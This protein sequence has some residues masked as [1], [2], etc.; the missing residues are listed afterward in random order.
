MS[1][2]HR[3][4]IVDDHRMLGELLTE[5]LSAEPDLRVAGYAPSADADIEGLLGRT[6]PDV[7]TVEIADSGDGADLVERIAAVSPRPRIVVLTASTDLAR[8][9][10]AAR[11]GA[12]AWLSKSAGSAE[13]AATVRAVCAGHTVYPSAQLGAVLRALA[14]GGADT[15][16]EPL[17]DL[18]R[19]ERRVLQG[20]VDGVR[21][22]DLAAALHVSTGTVRSHTRRLFLKLGVHSRLEAVRVARAAG[23]RPEQARSAE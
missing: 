11:A 3:V 5:S 8:M 23:F 10:A 12:D 16:G 15:G 6:R 14:G 13:L 21:G 2:I 19:Q 17:G 7:V 1:T 9:I 18:T 22:P 4:V 20:M